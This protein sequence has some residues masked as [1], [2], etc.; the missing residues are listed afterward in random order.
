MEVRGMKKEQKKIFGIALICAPLVS[1][2][3][4]SIMSIGLKFNGLLLVAI[5]A[6]F[7]VTIDFLASSD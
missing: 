3:V 6:I 1:L 5:C 4:F 7:F 2:I